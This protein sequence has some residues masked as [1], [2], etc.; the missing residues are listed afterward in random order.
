MC[1][2][3]RPGAAPRHQY[4][5]HQPQVTL[6]KRVFVLHDCCPQP[7]MV[8][9]SLQAAAD[10]F[11]LPVIK[12]FAASFTYTCV[13]TWPHTPRHVPGFAALGA[14]SVWRCWSNDRPLFLVAGCVTQVA[15]WVQGV[16]AIIVVTPQGSWCTASSARVYRG[17]TGRGGVQAAVEPRHCL[18]YPSC[19]CL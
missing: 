17:D 7:C 19:L 4:A 2:L 18:R 3:T 13:V 15:A 12:G 8:L 9:E 5:V 11:L 14:H 10:R 6:H 1:W 16:A